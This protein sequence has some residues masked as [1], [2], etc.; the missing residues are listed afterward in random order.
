MR[1]KMSVDRFPSEVAG[2]LKCYVYRLMDPRNGEIF[3]VGRGRGDRVFAHARGVLDDSPEEV[4]DPKLERIREIMAL[5]ME[6]HHIIHRH[7]MSEYA[8]KEVEAALIDAYPGLTNKV[9]GSGS[10]DRGTRHIREIMLEYGAEEF[11]VQEPLILISIANTWKQRGIYE[12]VRSVWGMKLSRA[13]R[14]SLVLAHVRGLVLGA[15][16]PTRWMYAVGN[17]SKFPHEDWESNYETL[18]G[19]IGFEGVPAKKEVWNRYVGKRV[20]SKYRRTGAQT[21]FRYVDP[22]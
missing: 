12:A 21:P 10:K 2:A 8:A 5:G 15:Y 18:K 1:N 14:Y 3:Y 7:G 11:V 17:K 16:K 13:K 22:D 6:V 9:T 20:P 19:R 4:A